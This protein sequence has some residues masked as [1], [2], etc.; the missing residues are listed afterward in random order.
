MKMGLFCA[1]TIGPSNN[2]EQTEN[3][4]RYSVLEYNQSYF[5]VSH[6]FLQKN[7]FFFKSSHGKIILL[8]N[9]PA[10]HP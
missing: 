7:I 9:D 5:V 3:R 6:F 4:R 2:D 10:N 8:N 1:P